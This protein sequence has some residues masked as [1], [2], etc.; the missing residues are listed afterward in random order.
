[1]KAIEVNGLGKCYRLGA[2][3]RY[4]F[5][6]DLKSAVGL[7]NRDQGE[8]FWA[9][10]DC[11]LT[12]VPG[13]V[14]GLIGK[15]GAGKS[16]L[17]KLLSR[18]TA[19]S[20]GEIRLHGRMAS[21]LEVGTGFHPELSGR[22][23]IY[24]NGAILGMRRAEVEAKFDEIVAFSGVERF[25]DTPV[26]RYSSGMYVRLAF[27]V[28]AHLEPEIL[29]IDEVLAVGDADFQRKCLGKMKDV[30]GEGR[31]VI[32]VSHNMAA[33]ENLCT[34]AVLLKG[35]QVQA[36]GPVRKVINQYLAG[37][38]N[39]QSTVY[40]TP[41]TAPGNELVRLLHAHVCDAGGKQFISITD[42]I[43]LSFTFALS[44]PE[45]D[46]N[47]SLNLFTLNGDHVFNTMSENVAANDKIIA[48]MTIPAEL[49]NS[50][51]YA[52]SIMAVR[53]RTVMLHYFENCLSFEVT[54]SRKGEVYF[55]E[56]GGVVRPRID[57]KMTPA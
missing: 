10:R 7:G 24:L 33:V 44:R 31:T 2:F 54:D 39:M 48:T 22:E 25:I 20:T 27:A 6:S 49:L 56:I 36:D 16:T 52:V 9:L 45:K 23:N 15:N 5:I 34:R 43:E 11:N 55:G 51:E 19:P 47:V 12:V 17:L 30:A 14:V 32:F 28:A 41:A 26:K 46:V 13:E 40:H 21:L 38:T 35:G 57:W 3:S 29:I 4:S 50:G 8:L 53:D 42:E 18:I 37:E 1:M